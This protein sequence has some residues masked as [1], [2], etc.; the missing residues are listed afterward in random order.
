MK[1]EKQSKLS[2]KLLGKLLT[3]VIILLITMISF[4]GIYVKDKHSMKNIIPEYKLGMDIFGARNIVITVNK[5]NETKKYDSEGN[6]VTEDLDEHNHEEE[7]EE[8][9]IDNNYTEVEEPI[10]NPELL[11]AENYNKVKSIILKRL[12]DMKI[13]NYLIRCNESTGEISLE[14]PEN[15]NTDYIVQYATAKGEFKLSDS[16]TSEVLL[17][18]EDI[19][20]AS[21]QYNTSSYGTTVYLTI[22]FNNKE[23]LKNIS[24]TYI[25]TN[26]NEGNTVAKEVK[27]TLDNQTIIT[28]HFDEEINDGII[29]LSIGTSTDNNE[30]QDYL[31]Q[32]ANMAVFLNTDPMPI[33]Y[34]LEI[35]RFVYSD[36]TENTLKVAIL[37]LSI[38]AALM[39]IYM[40]IKYHINGLMGVIVNIGFIAILLLALRYGNVTIS[41]MGIATIAIAFIIEYI[42]TMLILKQYQRNMEKE[43]IKK[44]LK[45][46]LKNISISMVPLVVMAITF[47]LATWEEISSIGMILFWSI[48]ILA[49]YNLVILSLQLFTNKSANNKN[50]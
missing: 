41:L 40:I 1:K 22:E 11:T 23:K 45:K 47:A 33:T 42:F 6:L 21:A 31:K 3:I 9:H 16:D 20:K 7:N 32:A 4:A 17:K 29:Y 28:T 10:N 34:E 14:V 19:K 27:M 5:N 46:I 8:E 39:G 50:S 12:K 24:N 26:D 2:L 18:N 44:D 15:S 13:S 25:E 37:V 38:I 30:I 43:T 48:L 35:N 49:I 36:I